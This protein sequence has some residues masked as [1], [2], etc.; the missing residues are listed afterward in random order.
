V[1]WAHWLSIVGRSAAVYVALLAGLRIG[2]LRQL[3]QLEKAVLEVDGSV[4]IIRKDH[5]MERSDAKLPS[6]RVRR[7][8]RPVPA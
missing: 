8:Y 4:S 5:T 1:E 7:K 3:G 6:R 2:G